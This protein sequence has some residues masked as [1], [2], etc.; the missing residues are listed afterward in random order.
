MGS[1]LNG[2]KS[3]TF[4]ITIVGTYLLVE[5]IWSRP[6]K[7]L[8]CISDSSTSRLSFLL[9]H[10]PKIE[11]VNGNIGIKHGIHPVG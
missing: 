2:N 4:F 11:M 3:K 5:L 10:I 6:R 7:S 8:A 9:P 1:I